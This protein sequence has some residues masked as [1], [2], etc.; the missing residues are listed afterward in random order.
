MARRLVGSY[1]LLHPVWRDG[2]G[3]TFIA[4]DR[5]GLPVSLR[6]LP[7]E[8]A[9]DDAVRRRFAEDGPLLRSLRH[10]NLAGVVDLVSAGET[11]AVVSEAV[12]GTTLRHRLVRDLP[13]ERIRRGVAA[14]LSAL[15]RAGLP[16]RLLGPATVMLTRSGEVRLTDIA[17]S[18]LLA[19]SAAGRALLQPPAGDREFRALVR[20]PLIGFPVRL[21]PGRLYST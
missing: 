20:R 9:G 3:A 18:R 11:L 10:P 2:L 16:H 19:D 17:L 14:G 4:R 15:R 5:C 13:R 1:E 6:V 12:V 7:A 21:T 8:L